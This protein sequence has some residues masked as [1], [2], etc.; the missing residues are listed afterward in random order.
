[1]NLILVE[2]H[3]VTDVI[4]HQLHEIEHFERAGKFEPH[5]PRNVWRHGRDRIPSHL[6]RDV[7][8]PD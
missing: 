2:P 3:I 1:V 7:K 4:A 8:R 6:L 5:N